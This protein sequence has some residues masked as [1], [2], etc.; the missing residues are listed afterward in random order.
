MEVS[1]FW[2]RVLAAKYGVTREVWCTR[3]VRGSHGY[4]LWKG[5][6]AN[7]D[8]FQKYI[9]FEVGKGDKVRFWHDKWC[10]DHSL[11]DD[12]PHLF[13]C[14][15]DREAL[16]DSLFSRSNGVETRKW[17]LQFVRNFNDWEV[18]M[19]AAFFNLIHS[20]SPVH[21]SDDVIKWSLKKNGTF[22]IRSFYH[23]I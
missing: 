15:R 11:K 22:D 9:V 16:I 8:V 17:Q 1:K 13:E 2:R 18:D 7:W 4:S 10:G 12:F 21:E 6:M 20:K 23:A 19:V 14:S 3:P 5:I